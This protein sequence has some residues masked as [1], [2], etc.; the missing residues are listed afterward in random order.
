MIAGGE[1]GEKFLLV[2]I[3]AYRVQWK[4]ITRLHTE[5]LLVRYLMYTACTGCLTSCYIGIGK[6]KSQLLLLR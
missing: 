2:K 6:L 5:F 3:S 4:N 1:I